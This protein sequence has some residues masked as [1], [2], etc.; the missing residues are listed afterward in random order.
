MTGDS[1]WVSPAVLLQGYRCKLWGEPSLGK[2]FQE[3]P[4]L[5]TFGCFCNLPGPQFPL[6]TVAN[7]YV[8]CPEVV[9]PKGAGAPSG[10]AGAEPGRGSH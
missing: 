4:G 7:D 1:E 3:P 10:A 5:V 9:R 2:V 8:L 6:D